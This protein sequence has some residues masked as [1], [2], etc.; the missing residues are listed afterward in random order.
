MSGVLFFLSYAASST[1]IL[2]ISIIIEFNGED[3]NFIILVVPAK[4]GC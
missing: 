1:E 3:E 4:T 2:E